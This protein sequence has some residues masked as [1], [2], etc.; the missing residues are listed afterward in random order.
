MSLA[1]R[2]AAQLE[3]LPEQQQ[4]EVLD[5]VEFLARK[6][7]K[8]ADDAERRE[9]SEGSLAGALR[10]MKEEPDLYTLA[11]IKESMA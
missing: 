1:E 10:G 5:F 9:W 3:T 6:Q 4:A 11:D 7:L 8:E 2:I